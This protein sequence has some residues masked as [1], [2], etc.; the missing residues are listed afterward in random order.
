MVGDDEEDEARMEERPSECKKNE[1]RSG[2]AMK[3]GN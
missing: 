2:A 3:K 1:R